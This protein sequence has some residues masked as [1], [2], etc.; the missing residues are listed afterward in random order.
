MTELPFT[1]TGTVE[2]GRSFGRT[3]D[4]PTAN[5]IPREDV[6]ELSFG[7][8]YSIITVDG[9]SYRAITNLG[10]RP[11]VE[12]GDFINAESFIYDFRGDLYDR[13]ISVKLLEFR[14]PEKKFD[15]FDE[16]SKAMHEDLEAG[17][18]YGK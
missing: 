2:H 13:D 14:R 3:I 5:I 8:Y 9:A 16:L 4:M 12:D 18:T 6:S 15:S 7:V 17:K 10:R 1:I 11:T